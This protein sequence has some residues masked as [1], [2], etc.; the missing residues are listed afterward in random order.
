VAYAVWSVKRAAARSIAGD[1]PGDE[2]GHHC[3]EEQ[4]RG[5]DQ[6][7]WRGRLALDPLLVLS[8]GW[9]SWISSWRSDAPQP[10]NTRPAARSTATP[11]RFEEIT[12]TLGSHGHTT[13]QRVAGAIM[14][15]EG[16][17]VTMLA[18]A[19]LFIRFTREMELRQRLVERD[20]DATR[21]ARAARY[22]RS[23]R[24]SD[25]T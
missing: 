21:A 19:W 1:E 23:V 7:Q 13:D 8:G 10:R 16:S 6:H 14:F 20:V 4:R 2:S 5:H 12:N 18:F 3:A 17:V 9:R 24:A 25:L 15:I 22:A 11:V